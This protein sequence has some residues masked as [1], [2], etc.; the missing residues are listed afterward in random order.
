MVGPKYI[1][2]NNSTENSCRAKELLQIWP[3]TISERR[4]LL[5]KVVYITIKMAWVIQYQWNTNCLNGGGA[6]NGS[7]KKSRLYCL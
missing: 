2:N 1:G 3:K 6:L 4:V 5:C 7:S